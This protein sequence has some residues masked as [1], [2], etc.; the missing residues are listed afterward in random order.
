MSTSPSWELYGAFLAVMAE[1]SLTGAATVLDV[2]QPTVRRRIE[3]LEDGLGVALFT[4]SPNGLLPTDAAFRALP[5]AESMDAAAR[6]LARTVAESHGRP[7]G[8][9]RVAASEVVGVEVLPPI[10]A[11]LRRDWPEIQVELVLSNRNE[12]LLRRDADIAVRMQAP[13]TS[14]LL[15]RRLG[16][17]PMGLFATPGYLAGRIPPSTVSDL[18]DHDLVGYDRQPL[19][20]QT[21]A[22]LGLPAER[23][24]YSLRTDH[25]LAYLAAVRAGVGVGVCQAPL[26]RDAVRLLPSI[27]LA[28]EMWL[29]THEDLRDVRRVRVVLD[30]LAAGLSTYLS[31]ARSPSPP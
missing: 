6:A 13:T 20:V 8:S 16:A 15:A 11:S 9:V 29:V 23:Q 22:Q 17:V 4:R 10:L 14:A 5:L 2:A 19:L 26:V 12:D 7:K 30:H 28:L 31:G 18:A 24:R 27:E 25:D 1:G 3:A 21:L